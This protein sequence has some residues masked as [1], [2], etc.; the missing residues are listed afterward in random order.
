MEPYPNWQNDITELVSSAS[1]VL[2]ISDLRSTELVCFSDYFRYRK[3]QHA[4]VLNHYA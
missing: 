4:R 2:D 1:S 3:L